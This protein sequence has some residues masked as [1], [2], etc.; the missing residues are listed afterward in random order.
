MS[1]KVPMLDKK[2]KKKRGKKGKN[3]DDEV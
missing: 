2:K 3:Q 1:S